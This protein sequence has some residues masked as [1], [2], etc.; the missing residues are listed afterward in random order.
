MDPGRK[1]EDE[2]EPQPEQLYCRRNGIDRPLKYLRNVVY[3]HL[4]SIC[5]ECINK[6]KCQE[7]EEK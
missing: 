5:K 7:K 4:S 1:H 6:P 3:W 2:H